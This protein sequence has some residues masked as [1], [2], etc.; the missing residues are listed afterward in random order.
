MK[1]I[2]KHRVTS[3]GLKVQPLMCP[4]HL[5]MWPCRGESSQHTKEQVFDLLC[6][7]MD[8]TWGHISK[9]SAFQS[10]LNNP[11][12]PR[13]GPSRVAEGTFPLSPLMIP[14]LTKA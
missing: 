7:R 6:R 11:E 8:S 10:S 2:N 13:V 5:S 14:S 4:Y 9:P 3:L 12:T 1:H